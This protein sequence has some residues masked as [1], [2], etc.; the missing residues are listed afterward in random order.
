M[1]KSFR[2]RRPSAPLIISVVALFFALG[3]VGYAAVALPKN[4]VGTKQIRNNAVTYQ[5]IAP[6]T[7]GSA[8]INQSLVQTR[9]TGTC[10]GTTGAIGAVTQSGHVTC[11]PSA[12]QEFG[13]SSTGTAVT[14]TAATVASRS[15]AA[16]SYLVFGEAY[17]DNTGGTDS[18]LTCTL[19]VPSGSTQARTVT[20]PAGHQV[21]LPI[22]LA[23]T[24]PT[25]GATSTLACTQTGGTAVSVDG[26]INAIQ[27]ASNS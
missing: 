22:N 17:A 24:A 14:G 10:T 16:G 12:P 1:S 18:V 11:N 26:Q 13:S 23:S 21:A 6:G 8:R 4:S 15:L 7:V 25:G 2:L 19:S 3:G 20:V 9:V 27:T 5:K